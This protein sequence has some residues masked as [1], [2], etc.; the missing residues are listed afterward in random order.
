MTFTNAPPREGRFAETFKGTALISFIAQILRS[1][2]SVKLGDSMYTPDGALFHLRRLRVEVQ[3]KRSLLNEPT[4]RQK[5]VFS[6]LDVDCPF[7]TLESGDLLRTPSF[8]S[9]G[10]KKNSGDLAGK[11][12]N[13][14]PASDDG[15]DGDFR[16]KVKRGRPKGS[17]NKNKRE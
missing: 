15:N 12:E 13:L 4:E 5:D 10:E 1:Y 16:A 2:L 7:L 3:K 11:P 17:K 6:R 8:K 9:S 14:K